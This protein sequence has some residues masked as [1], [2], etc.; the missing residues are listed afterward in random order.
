MSEETKSHKQE[1]T[2]IE[3]VFYSGHEKRKE[4]A[5]FR[6]SK[7]RLKEDGHYKCY[8]NNSECK[9]SLEA[10]HRGCEYAFENDVD[11][12]KL[13]AF[14]EEWD[15]Y[16]YSK[17]LKNQPIITPDDIRNMMVVC[18]YHHTHKETGIHEITF[19][20]WIMQK[21]EKRGVDIIPDEK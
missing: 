3:V 13:K 5:E 19:P 2:I 21:L 12:E 11:F 20:I 9:G 17:L 6:K 10:H 4:S 16:G 14:L 1:R 7:K 18:K 8:I 15:L